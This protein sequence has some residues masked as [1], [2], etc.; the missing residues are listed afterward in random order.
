MSK[1]YLHGLRHNAKIGKFVAD[2]KDSDWVYLTLNGEKV[3]RQGKQSRGKVFAQ[4][5]NP[6]YKGRESF[7]LEYLK[8]GHW[9]TYNSQAKTGEIKSQLERLT[10]AIA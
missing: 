9:R 6:D 2:T 7:A 1:A 4:G 5:S 10:N 3:I 8:D